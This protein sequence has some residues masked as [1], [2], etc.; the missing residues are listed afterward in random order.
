MHHRSDG[1]VDRA[2]QRG[3]HKHRLDPAQIGPCRKARHVGERSSPD[4][5]HRVA[6]ANS[7]CGQ[8]P[9]DIFHDPHPLCRLAIG[10]RHGE[11]GPEV[12]GGGE[13]R[14]VRG[15]Y[16]SGSLRIRFRSPRRFFSWIHLSFDARDGLVFFR[17]FGTRSASA[18]RSDNFASASSRFRSCRR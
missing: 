6:P 18:T 12:E 10:K 7:C 16:S 13:D 15:G 11:G 5:E 9:K 8:L 4:A 2:Q 3:W 14:E 1:G 17:R